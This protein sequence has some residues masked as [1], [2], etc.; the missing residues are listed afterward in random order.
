[1]ITR[2]GGVKRTEFVKATDKKEASK[3]EVVEEEKPKKKS[4]KTGKLD[5]SSDEEDKKA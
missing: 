5:E 1:M 3:V 2:T 4:K